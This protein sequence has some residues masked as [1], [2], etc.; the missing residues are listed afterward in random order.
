MW[1]GWVELLVLGGQLNKKTDSECTNDV[2]NEC[3]SHRSQTLAKTLRLGAVTSD[4]HRGGGGLAG[5]ACCK[6]PHNYLSKNRWDR[7]EYW[8]ACSNHSRLHLG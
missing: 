2:L 7:G 4:C 6:P 5:P 8:G 1:D 3:C